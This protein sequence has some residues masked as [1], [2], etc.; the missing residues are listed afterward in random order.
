MPEDFLT[1]MCAASRE[2]VALARG[3]RA[4]APLA[5]PP[6]ADRLFAA[7][8]ARRPGLGVIAEIKRASPSRGPIDLKLDAAEQARCYE[9]AGAD[10]ISVLTEPHSFL[11]SLTDLS[12]AAAASRLP[13][14]RK[15]FIVDEYQLLEAQHAGAAAVL[16]IVAALDDVELEHLLSVCA[17]L[18]LDALVE[19]HDEPEIERA[20][21][22]GCQL[23]GINNRDLRTLTVNLAVTERLAPLALADGALVVSES[24]ITDG[25]DAARV[26]A[27]GASAVLVGEALVRAGEWSVA[28]RIAE[29]K[30]AARDGA[31]PP[32]AAGA[33]QRNVT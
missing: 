20:L 7:L 19:T 22:H 30:V 26:A 1:R 28:A 23:I 33:D 2:R 17:A 3:A 15:D 16:L 8:A 11:G 29:F 4:L 12:A 14:L 32:A 9:I 18:G 5:S 13:L 25:A 10:A 21:A 27:A 31:P 24:G 6:P